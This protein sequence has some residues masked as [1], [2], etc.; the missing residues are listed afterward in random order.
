MTKSCLIFLAVIVCTLD[1]I[2]AQW[3]TLQLSDPRVAPAGV[4]AAGKVFFAGGYTQYTPSYINSNKISIY[5]I[6]S[7]TWLPDT[8]SEARNGIATAV[9]GDQ[10]IFAGGRKM[11]GNS[12]KVDIYNTSSNTWS[13]SE[14][15]THR[16]NMY[17]AVIGD[18]AYFI[19]GFSDINNDSTGHIMTYHASLN[20]WGFINVA[21]IRFK[22]G[23]AVSGTKIIIA[24]GYDDINFSTLK[25]VDI[26]NTQAGT[27]TTIQMPAPRYGQSVFS[28]AN[29]IYFVGGYDSND[30]ATN[31]IFIYDLSNSSWSTKLYSQKR[32][33]PGIAMLGEKIYLAGGAIGNTK[34]SSVEVFNTVTSTFESQMQLSQ[35]RYTISAVACNDRLFFAGGYYNIDFFNEG[36]SNVV[37]IFAL[38]THVDNLPKVKQL[39]VRPTLATDQVSIIIEEAELL[40]TQ[41]LDV[42]DLNG[43]MF[44]VTSHFESDSEV[45]INISGLPNGYYAI[46]FTTKQGNWIGHFVKQ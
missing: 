36:I 3:S 34:F 26:Y 10:V 37:D 42:F 35:A 2:S 19:S 17:G 11:G 22:P 7:Q 38:T 40:N 1:T 13:Q 30:A 15:P 41:N 6:A 24:G 28:L 43:R 25:S 21:T 14:M 45:K 32:A 33:E 44:S 27:W 12:N 39:Q 23:V 5:D 4:Y 18:I 8:L 20:T 46:H 31:T 9:V 16:G 29:K